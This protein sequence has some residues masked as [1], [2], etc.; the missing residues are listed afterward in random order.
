MSF[1]FSDSNGDSSTLCDS[2]INHRKG[3]LF[4]EKILELGQD[5]HVQI[6]NILFTLDTFIKWEDRH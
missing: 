5:V 2:K 4:D 6:S 1:Y 3:G